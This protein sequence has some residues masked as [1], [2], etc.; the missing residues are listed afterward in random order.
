MSGAPVGAAGAAASAGNGGTGGLGLGGAG[1][2]GQGLGGAGA[3]GQT[4]GGAGT[5]G[6]GGA[7]APDAAVDGP[8]GADGGDGK[9]DAPADQ[10]CAGSACTGLA[11]GAHCTNSSQCG[12]GSCV[13]GVC[14]ENKCASKCYSCVEV[15]TTQPDGT[16]AAVKAHTAHGADCTASPKSSCGTSGECDGLGGCLVWPANTI[17]QT[18]VCAADGRSATRPSA[19]NGAG[20]CVG[21][22]WNQCIYYGCDTT[23]GDCRT[24]CATTADCQPPYHCLGDHTCGKAADGDVCV[25]NEECVSG[26]CGGRCC[27]T[28]ALNCTCPQPSANNLL[29]N[30]GFDTD[31]TTGWTAVIPPGTMHTVTWSTMDATN[32]S[33]SGSAQLF[34]DTTLPTYTPPAITQCVPVTAGMSY[35]FGFRIQSTCGNG[36]CTVNFFKASNCTGADVTESSDMPENGGTPFTDFMDSGPIVAPAE[37][38]GALLTCST[39]APYGGPT[40]ATWFDEVYFSPSPHTY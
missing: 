15:N 31:V 29:T 37:A 16:C 9:V 19:C 40:C 8:S 11:R 20:S 1:A 7:S 2:A 34:Y 35:E 3:A 17:C 18:G 5:V 24:S 33:Y 28:T 32:C 23:V 14:C 21:S 4:A 30:A 26:D 27:P 36:W 12:T 6:Q 13:E 22:G 38:R 39:S 25:A 10:T